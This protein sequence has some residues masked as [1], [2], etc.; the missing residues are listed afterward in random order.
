MNK[1]FLFSFCLLLSSALSAQREVFYPRIENTFEFYLRE[2]G[3]QTQH[4]ELRFFYPDKKFF[5]NCE[6]W[7]NDGFGVICDQKQI[8]I[9]G[10]SEA[11]CKNAIYDILQ[12]KFN[13]EYFQAECTR[14]PN[15]IPVKLPYDRYESIPAFQYRE[16][17]YGETRRTGY[18]E[19]H[20]LTSGE[21][22]FTFENHPGWGLW[23]HTLHKLLPPELHFETHPEYY[24]LR[25]GI[26]MKDQVCL[27]NPEVLN[28]VCDNLALEMRKKPDAK[29]WSVSQMDNYNYCECEKCRYI[30][31]LEH[32]H[33]GTML[34]FV[35]EVAKRFPNKIISTLA[36]QYTRSAPILTKPE[37]N[38]NIMLCTIEENRAKSLKG[39]GFEKDLENWTKLTNNILIWDYVINFSHL[40]MPFPNWPTLQENIQIFQAYGVQ[41]LFEQGLNSPSSEMQPLRA[42]LLS[43]WSWDPKLNADSLIYEFTEAYYGPGGAIVREVLRAQVKDLQ[44]SGKALTLY[45]PPITHI[46]GYLSP[47][48]L[49]WALLMYDK[50]KKLPGMSSLQKERIDMCAQ[51]IR[52]ALL[53]ISK[54]P[55]AGPD[56]YFNGNQ[57]FYHELLNE[58]MALLLK[59]GPILLHETRLKPL[60]Y[61]QNT[62]QFWQEA[63]VSH[64]A[65]QQKIRYIN[66]PAKAY[67]DGLEVSDTISWTQ[68]AIIN[69]GLRSTLEYQKGWQG[70]QGKDAILELQL[71][72]PY[73]IDSVR[74]HYLANN[75]SWIMAPSK[76]I[77]GGFTTANESFLTTMYHPEVGAPQVNGAY[78]LV[79][80]NFPSSPIQTFKL[81][82]GNPGPLPKWRGV[83]GDGWLFIDEIEVYGHEK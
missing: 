72:R 48:N 41:M 80:E 8:Q 12:R 76:I 24:A 21:S 79:L 46:S 42:F 63:R 68:K 57:I 17:F 37:A 11:A 6:K 34:R 32:S 1:I 10:Y 60:E 20:K 49:K 44:N 59:N 38:V 64:L 23:V 65:K 62:L 15:K 51:S 52:Y 56:W 58:F 29:Y 9:F 33:A 35:N 66:L 18:G 14:I 78:P 61:K 81:T 70:W 74:I 50:A 5:P 47:S 27:S 36:Y 45:E 67:Q 28:L 77:A 75:Q 3:Q 2:A 25:N 40:V 39:S 69:D 13:F 71:E 22:S 83:A 54:S 7:G 53:E 26:R 73:L 4:F 82:V 16:I 19:W 30:D 43:K 31:S 55:L